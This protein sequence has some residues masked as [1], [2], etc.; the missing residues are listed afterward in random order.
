MTRADIVSAARAYLGVRYVHQGRSTAGMDCL[1]LLI[2][3]GRDLG[4]LPHDYDR[5]DYT[6][7]PSA[8]VLL[9]GMTDRLQ[10][11]ALAEAQPGDILVL[12]SAGQPVHVGIKSDVGIVHAYGP[13]G[14]VVE[15]GLRAQFATAVRHAFRVPGVV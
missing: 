7:Q 6:H 12:A 10:P 15:H 14:R 13:A 11:I 3:V 5:Q 9:A 2:C 1:G 8:P 4:F